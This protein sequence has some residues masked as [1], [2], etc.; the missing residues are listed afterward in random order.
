LPRIPVVGYDRDDGYLGWFDADGTP[1]VDARPRRIRLNAGA[2]RPE[3]NF[4]HE[5][6]HYIEGFAIPGHKKM[7]RDWGRDPD[8]AAWKAAVEGSKAWKALDSLVGVDDVRGRKDGRAGRIRVKQ[9]EVAYL[10][11]WDELWARAYA[12]YVAVR[13]GDAVLRAQLEAAR[14]RRVH[15][16]YF[17]R[18]WDEA[19]F[20]PIAAA[21]D[22]LFRRLKWRA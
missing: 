5:L 16:I 1:G 12:Q 15:G 6:G 18:Q 8:L 19:D 7:G 22:E 21:I 4:L 2:T 10:L 14:D 9:D 13:S 3:L 17:H 11:R 20:E